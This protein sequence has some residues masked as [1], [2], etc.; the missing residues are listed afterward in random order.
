MDHPPRQ[1]L[2]APVARLIHFLV[3]Y[4]GFQEGD[5]EGVLKGLTVAGAPFE[6]RD[7]VQIVP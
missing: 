5:K 3:K 2:R 7:R 1:P 6:G 4:A